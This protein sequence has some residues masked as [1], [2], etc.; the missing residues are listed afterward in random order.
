MLFSPKDIHVRFLYLAIYNISFI[1]NS[2]SNIF[3][4]QLFITVHWVMISTLL[5]L[6]KYKLNIL[7][8][9]FSE[10]LRFTFG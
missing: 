1:F 10:T 4:M 8:Y 2:W 7:P 6:E 3:K 5:F 9:D